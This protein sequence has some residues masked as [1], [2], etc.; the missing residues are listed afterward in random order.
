MI[1]S[2]RHKALGNFFKTGSARGLSADH[3]PRLRR[4]LTAMHAAED[5]KQLET[6]PGWR[7]H[8][9]KG[10]KAGFWSLA[11]TGNWRLV[12]KWNDGFADEIDLVDYH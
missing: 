9:L 10:D 2:F 7:L 6:V 12:F 8:E 11:V 3:V 4:L 5:L 1:G